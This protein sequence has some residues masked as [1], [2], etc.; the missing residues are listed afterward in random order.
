V[1][2]ENNNDHNTTRRRHVVAQRH[3]IGPDSVIRNKTSQSNRSHV[4]YTSSQQHHLGSRRTP[5]TARRS[6]LSVSMSR[7]VWYR[8]ITRRAR[9]SVL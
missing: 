3:K 2:E 8:I 6:G 7:F 9:C 5:R 4:Y 1:K